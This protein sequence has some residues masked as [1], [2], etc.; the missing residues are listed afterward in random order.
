[1]TQASGFSAGLLSP[2]E[3]RTDDMAS[4]AASKVIGKGAKRC[5]GECGKIKPYSEFYVR[6][7][8]GTLD[9][10]AILD[11]HF[12]S[13]CIACMKKRSQD[14]TRIVPWES[15]VIAEQLAIIAL[16]QAGI[17]AQTG[18]ATSAPDVDVVAWGSVW[19]EVK[20]AK[21]RRKGNKQTFSFVTTPAQQERGFLAH[22][23]M[24][25]C[26]YPEARFTYHLFHADNPIFHKANGTVKSGFTY[27]LGRMSAVAKGRGTKDQLTLPIMNESQNDWSIIELHRQ[28]IADDL[29]DGEIPEYG[30][31]F[32]R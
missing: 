20:H 31:P 5:S 28:W 3:T 1:M 17:W 32:A 27:S 30:R 26:E 29:K 24:L 6:S 13:E 14:Q 25:I 22:V 12:V 9:N 18:K 4:I 8:Y 2:V 21:L 11:G 16:Q 7:G 15:H 19:I 10:P 23:V